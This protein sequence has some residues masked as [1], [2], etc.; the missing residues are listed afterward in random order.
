MSAD[1]IEHVWRVTDE[2]L[3]LLDDPDTPRIIRSFARDIVITGL[4]LVRSERAYA[5]T[6]E[7]LQRA[8]D[9]DDRFVLD[10]LLVLP[11]LPE[12]ESTRSSFVRIMDRALARGAKTYT[13]ESLAL[14]MMMYD[15]PVPA[16]CLRRILEKTTD[17]ELTAPGGVQLYWS[18]LE[19]PT[20]DVA[21]LEEMMQARP[22]L[23]A[24]MVAYDK[25]RCEKRP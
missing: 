8:V 1:P 17:E 9:R 10:A 15:A 20:A 2:H 24:A 14:T 5:R 19:Q 22:A 13:L 7:V 16:E 3:T 18:W 12:T 4:L 23:R 11:G 25:E 21:A 6:F